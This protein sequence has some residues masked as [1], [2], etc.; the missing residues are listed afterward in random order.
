MKNLGLKDK[1]AIVTGG[2]R[3]IGAAIVR[4]LAHHGVKVAFSYKQQ[5]SLANKLVKELGV[6]SFQIDATDFNGVKKMVEEIYQ[7]FGIIDIL[8]NN[9]G[10]SHGSP[11]WQMTEEQWNAVITTNLKSFYNYLRNVVPIFVKNR[12]GKIITI[13]SVL[14]LRG[15]VGELN[16]AVT[17]SLLVGFTK[18]LTRELGQFNINVN[19][20]APGYIDTESQQKNTPEIIRKM[21]LDECA[22]KRLG[23]PEDIANLVTFLCSSKAKQITGEI[24]KVDAGQYI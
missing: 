20:I 19:A 14:G 4:D 10:I 24:I 13:T 23:K 11:I 17:K 9:V 1:V 7:R 15:R 12:S 6:L 2:S 18:T 22:I 21:V 16:Y 3:G 8:I 5:T